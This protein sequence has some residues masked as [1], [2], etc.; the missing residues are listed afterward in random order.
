MRRSKQRQ[1]G[2]LREFQKLSKRVSVL[3]LT[4]LILSAKKSEKDV[5]TL[6]CCLSVK[7]ASIL[8]IAPTNVALSSLVVLEGSIQSVT[9]E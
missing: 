4:L 9:K 8:E 1:W 3:V 5:L 6:P 7:S 2:I